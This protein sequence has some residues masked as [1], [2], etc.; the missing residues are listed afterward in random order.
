MERLM[1]TLAL[2]VF[3]FATQAWSLAIKS[4][5]EKSDIKQS[6][7]EAVKK[8]VDDGARQQYDADELRRSY[9]ILLNSMNNA[10]Q[11]HPFA[12]AKRSKKN[13]P[14]AFA[15]DHPF[16]F[17]QDHPF[18]FPKKQPSYLHGGKKRD[19]LR[20]GVNSLYFHGKRYVDANDADEA[21]AY[22]QNTSLFHGKR[23]EEDVMSEWLANQQDESPSTRMLHGKRD[24]DRVMLRLLK[25]LDNKNA[26]R[27]ARK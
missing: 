2:L 5:K 17:S 10:Q 7:D 1:I 15:Q 8:A 4:D 14:F 18:L 26:Q 23:S 19:Y 20:P 11:D 21:D 22:D 6:N 3:T 9:E 24:M 13:H 25:D 16:S 27:N 12:F